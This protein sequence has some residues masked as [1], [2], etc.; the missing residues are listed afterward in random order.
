MQ[1]NPG[2]K[3]MPENLSHAVITVE[4]RNQETNQKE[5]KKFRCD[6][7]GCSKIYSTAGNLKTHQKTHTGDISFIIDISVLVIRLCIIL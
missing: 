1:I 7:E 3:P 6:Y 5:Y 2:N 4:S